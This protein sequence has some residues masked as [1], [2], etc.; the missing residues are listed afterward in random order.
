[1]PNLVIVSNRLPVSVKRVDGKLEFYESVGGL[2][3]GLS[4]Y[5]KRSGTKWIGWPG[6]PSD[7]L[8]RFE[9]NQI[10]REL[11]KHRCYPLFLTKKQIDDYYNGYS[12]GVLWPRLHNL[13]TVPHGPKF[14]HAYRQVNTLFAEE[15]LRRSR[16]RSMVW[17]HDYQ[18]MLVPQ[19]LRRAGRDDKIGF[20]LHIPFPEPEV[21]SQISEAKSLL[22]GM[23]GADLVG[24]HTR[25]YTKQFSAAC[26]QLLGLPNTQGQLLMGTRPV[27]ATEFPM[28]IDYTRFA[29]ATKQRGKR[30]ELRAL[31]KQ[32]RKHKVIVTV[33]RLDPTKGLVER[34][35]AYQA[36]LRQY[37]QWHGKVLMAMIVA[38]S[39]TDIDEYKQLKTRLDAVLADISKEFATP[40]WRPVDFIYETVP[41]DRVMLYY[42]VADVAFIAPIRDGM[43]L[44]AKEFIATKQH[45]NGVLVLSET[46]GAAEELHGAIRVNPERPQTM[47][48][49]LVEA[50]A[51]P[52]RELRQRARS[53]QQHIKEFT[54]QKW[55][56]SFMDVLQKPRVMALE[57][58][59]SITPQTESDITLA[60][61]AAK[62]RLF[63]LDYDG[64]L[65]RFVR[66]PAEAEPSAK[67]MQ[68]L[69]RLSNDKANE[70][71]LISGRSKADLLNW[72]GHLPIALAAE[73]GVLFRRQGAKNWHKTVV[74]DR[75]WKH[76]VTH[77]C[78]Y[79]A[80]LTPEWLI[81]DHDFVLAAG[82]DITDEALFAA[83]PPSAHTIK[84]GRG[85]T[86]ARLR[87]T[88]VPDILRL[89]QKISD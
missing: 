40:R 52:K 80:E 12:N 75:N 64:V 70:V 59:R 78:T 35:K 34:L 71:V 57:R 11:R 7:D 85:K 56:D 15:V 17:V 67:L 68:I 47:V 62:R 50:L 58:T 83:M 82:D 42:Q 76:E 19:L 86:L 46:A 39:R 9:R 29:A 89:L 43:N 61:C 87:A 69:Q 22:R 21:F 41:L 37:P 26:E 25:G 30:K 79:Y 10:M 65:R 36:L 66:N 24:F 84:V 72:F 16:P 31:R 55:A 74:D 38:P 2:A 32:Y 18:L 8:T 63:L 54:V 53:M 5:T 81:H 3:T 49:G 73:H 28:G 45:N 13:E 1:M 88:G 60:Y 44:V 77:I 23:L 27:R 14:W 48:D 4:E 33:D 51:M 6:I 20:F